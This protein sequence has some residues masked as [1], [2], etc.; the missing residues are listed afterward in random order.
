[1]AAVVWLQE[2]AALTIV[3]QAP[4]ECTSLAHTGGCTSVLQY[5]HYTITCMLCPLAEIFYIPGVATR[6]RL[7]GFKFR[8]IIFRLIQIHSIK[9]FCFCC[10]HVCCLQPENFEKK[11]RLL[12]RPVRAWPPSENGKFDV[13]GLLPPTKQLGSQLT[14]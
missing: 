12:P 8:F 6:S 4:A 7:I 10:C 3:Y 13:I 1:M 5:G 11:G 14:A 2:E 9:R